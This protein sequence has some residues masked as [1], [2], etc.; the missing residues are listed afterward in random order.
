[1]RVATIAFAASQQ[2]FECRAMRWREIEPDDG[3]SRCKPKKNALECL[4]EHQ[5][6]GARIG[7]NE[8]L[9]G[10]GEPPVQRHQH[11]AESCAC[12]E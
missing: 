6:L 9:L 5:H 3:R 11:R 4:L 12:V 1:M 10:D 7:E 8:E 2:S